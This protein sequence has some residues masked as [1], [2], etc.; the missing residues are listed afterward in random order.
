MPRALRTTTL[1]ALLLLGL[2]QA[3]P[4]LAAPANPPEK[5]HALAAPAKPPEKPDAQA[6]RVLE[7]TNA[8]RAKVGL[9]ALRWNGLLATTATDYAGDLVARRYFS[10][11]SKEGT[12][13]WDRAKA[14]GYPSYGW[15]ACYVGENLAQGY[16]TPE[17]AVKAWM[18]SEG[19]RANILKPE[20]RELGVG[21]VTDATGRKT[22]VQ[23]FGAR[24]GV[25]P[26]V[27]D[28]DADATDSP[29]VT[30]SIT[31]EE[32]SD[33][34]SVGKAVLMEVSNRPD[35]ADAAW[36][37]YTK[38]RSW[39]LKDEPGTERVYV[40][41]KDSRG[42]VVESSDDIQLTFRQAA[43]ALQPASL[44]LAPQSS[45]QLVLPQSQTRPQYQLGFKTLA[46][47]IP[48][49]AGQPLD[50]EHPDDN[51]DIVQHTTRGLMVW[52]KADNWTAFTDG[53][54]TWVDG[55]DG[56]QERGNDERFPWEPES[57][58]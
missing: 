38:S 54:R 8:E 15:G 2:L 6:W 30:L 57:I 23:N 50:E 10:H 34:G 7:L 11:T 43:G 13:P 12:Q 31:S 29:M 37:S 55:P 20:Y 4:I 17:D 26:V 40:R 36:E 25:L 41:L 27:I 58:P 53:S 56:V 32:V 35:F 22:W 44:D 9:T 19:H 18:N 52:R 33:W 47:L 14:H 39:V 1:I 21:V 46:E 28:G 3:A 16:A 48:Q 5:S 24:P 49:V 45:P 51:G 42:A